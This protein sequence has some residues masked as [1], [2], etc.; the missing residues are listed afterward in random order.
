MFEPVH[1][2]APDIAGQSEANPIAMIMSV[3]M[4]FTYGLNRRDIG[5]AITAA[6]DTVLSDGIVTGDQ[7]SGGRVYATWEVGQAVC[8]ALSIHA[9]AAGEFA[10][11]PFDAHL[12]T[13][14]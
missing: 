10:D 5:R 12:V 8:D 4:M 14:G 3:A 6:V 7:V 2:S 9:S 13:R 1:G 11:H